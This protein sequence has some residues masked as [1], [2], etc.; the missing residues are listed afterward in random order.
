MWREPSRPRN[1]AADCHPERSMIV[2]RT[3]MRSRRIP[4]S[5]TRRPYPLLPAPYQ[6]RL[7][8]SSRFSKAGDFGCRNAGCP[9]SRALCEK[10]GFFSRPINPLQERTRLFTQ[11]LRM[12]SSSS[13]DLPISSPAPATWAA[14]PH[15]RKFQPAPPEPAANTTLCA[16]DRTQTTAAKDK[17]CS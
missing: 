3:F 5:T 2:R 12:F 16:A 17:G 13:C 9:I 11:P 14:P 4:I 15:S 6:L 7:P 1:A 10:W 8:R